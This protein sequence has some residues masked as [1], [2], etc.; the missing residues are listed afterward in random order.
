MS[1]FLIYDNCTLQMLAESNWY[2][3]L[4]QVEARFSI[5]QEVVTKTGPNSGLFREKTTRLS[6]AF[7]TV[8]GVSPIANGDVISVFYMT[9][10]AIRTQPQTIR[11]VYTDEDGNQKQIS[12]SALIVKIEI[13][14]PQKDFT[15]A[16][17]D[18]EFSG[19]IDIEDVTAPPDGTI[20]IYADYWITTAGQNYLDGTQASVQLGYY[21]NTVGLTI[22]EVIREGLE[23]DFFGYSGTPGNRQCIYNQTTDRLI[24][25]T[26]FISGETVTVI[27]KR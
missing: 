21:L 9:Q 2:D 3:I 20:Q 25:N 5:Q 13:G 26:D 11:F 1:D 15:T 7:A 19:A 6:E 12:G 4:C 24:F 18:F 14:S 16:T 10:E 17:I 23:Y 8:T 22:L 27:F